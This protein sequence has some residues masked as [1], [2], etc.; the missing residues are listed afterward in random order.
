MSSLLIVFSKATQLR[1]EQMESMVIGVTS[2]LKKVCNLYFWQL[3]HRSFYKQNL[4]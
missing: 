1:R 4:L 2:K 3:N